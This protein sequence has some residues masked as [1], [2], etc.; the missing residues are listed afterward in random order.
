MLNKSIYIFILEVYIE[1]S[2]IICIFL[3]DIFDFLGVIFGLD[4]D[5]F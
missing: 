3:I 4:L 2:E 1:Y 5:F